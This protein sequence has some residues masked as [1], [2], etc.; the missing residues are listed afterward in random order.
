MFIEVGSASSE[1]LHESV[2]DKFRIKM[3]PRK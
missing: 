3:A 2:E 1:F